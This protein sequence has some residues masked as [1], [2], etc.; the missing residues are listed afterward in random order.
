[1][2]RRRLV[3]QIKPE[4]QRGTRRLSTRS[5]VLPALRGRHEE[6]S[7]REMAL[8]RTILALLIL[9]ILFHIGMAYVGV[10]A[11]T[12]GLT[13]AI[14]SLGELIES[15]AQALINALPLTEEQQDVAQ[16]NSFYIVAL[17]AAGIYFLL[18]LLL[19]IGRRD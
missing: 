14:Y 12:N 11:N 16:R 13:S 2:V 1:M 7:Y 6:R 3:G 19:G 4:T 8:I 9:V 15:P 18:Y 17:T 5:S 10:E